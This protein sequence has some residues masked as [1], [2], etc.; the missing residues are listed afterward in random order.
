MQKGQRYGPAEAASA[1]GD[2]SYFAFEFADHGD[3]LASGILSPLR[4]HQVCLRIL[5]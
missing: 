5:L 2:K 4:V 3:L 1:T